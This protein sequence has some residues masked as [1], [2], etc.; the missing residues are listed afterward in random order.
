[1]VKCVIYYEIRALCPSLKGIHFIPYFFNP[2]NSILREIKDYFIL[3][4]SIYLHPLVLLPLICTLAY[5]R[6][7]SFFG[8][9]PCR[10]K[11]VSFEKSKQLYQQESF[12]LD[13]G[14]FPWFFTIG[15][16]FLCSLWTLQSMSAYNSHVSIT[17]LFFYC[18]LFAFL[19]YRA[20]QWLVGLCGVIHR[21]LLPYEHRTNRILHTR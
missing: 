6:S 12:H 1:M 21:S 4:L 19:V 18:N 3:F 14:V 5:F 20:F 2:S 7:V 10:H 9:W 17:N 15:D 8:Q 13:R 16:L 11:V